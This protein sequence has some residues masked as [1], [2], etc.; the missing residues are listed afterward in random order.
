MQEDIYSKQY[1]LKDA[2]KKIHDC[3]E[4]LS[5]LEQEIQDLKEHVQ[6]KER[7]LQV[8]TLQFIDNLEHG[9][10]YG[11][12]GKKKRYAYDGLSGYHDLLFTS[13]DGEGLYVSIFESEKIID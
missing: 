8:A 5:L 11:L 10:Y 1:K 7:D 6:D 13:R 2:R 4:E 12:E 9:L 3:K